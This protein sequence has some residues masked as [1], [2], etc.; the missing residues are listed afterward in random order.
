M[1]LGGNMT[2]IWEMR[3]NMPGP[4]WQHINKRP[5]IMKRTAKRWTEEENDKLIELK[6][7]GVSHR[8]IA[9]ALNEAFNNNRTPTSIDARIMKIHNNGMDLDTK[10]LW[11]DEETEMLTH[12][13]K[14]N[15]SRPSIVTIL[16]SA[17]DNDRTRKAIGSKLRLLGLSNPTKCS[18]CKEYGHNKRTCPKFKEHLELIK[19]NDTTVEIIEE[20]VEE[21]E[22]EYVELERSSRKRWTVDEEQYM[23]ELAYNQV[24]YSEITEKLNEEFDS[25][26]STAAII[27]RLSVM[28]SGNMRYLKKSWKDSWN[29]RRLNRKEKRIQKKI[30]RIQN[31]IAKLQVRISALGAK[32]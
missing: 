23:V 6:R 14:T 10:V 20:V 19:S 21:M 24:P 28:H 13:H 17:F 27:S 5:E 18:Y 9:N 3:K 7:D 29:E 15:E 32:L 31:K 1:V 26:R 11:S 2:D 22:E 25:G 8:G 16:N 30:I 4:K 12:L